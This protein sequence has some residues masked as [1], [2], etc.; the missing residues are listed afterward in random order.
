MTA[1]ILATFGLTCDLTG[2]LFLAWSLFVN[3]QKAVELGLSRWSGG[4]LEENLKL[5]AVQDRLVQSNRAVWGCIFLVLG[6]FLQIAAVWSVFNKSNLIYKNT[7]GARTQAFG[8]L[9][10]TTGKKGVTPTVTAVT[11][12]GTTKAA[13]KAAVFKGGTVVASSSIPATISVSVLS[14]NSG[15]TVFAAFFGAVVAFIALCWNI[16]TALRDK[17]RLKVEA[18]VGFHLEDTK[19]TPIISIYMTN[20]GRRPLYVEKVHGRLSEGI[21]SKAPYFFMRTHNLPKILNEGEPHV[22]WLPFKPDEWRK[23]ADIYVSTSAGD[24][25]GL[26]R[27]VRLQLLQDIKETLAKVAAGQ[28][29]LEVEKKG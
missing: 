16:M 22:E 12:S 11:V 21:D 17:G 4:T 28:E 9:P 14:S 8:A 25:Y 18:T 26:S 13:A 5:P 27:K 6:A 20:I 23:I 3:K 10:I 1:R 15:V 7:E 19:R 2:A 24:K 29:W